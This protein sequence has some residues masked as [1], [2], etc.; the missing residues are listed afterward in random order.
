MTRRKL[1]IAITAIAAALVMGQCYMALESRARADGGPG[2]EARLDDDLTR[3]LRQ[4]KFTGRI[5]DQLERRLGRDL[6]PDRANLGRLLFFDKILGLNNDNACAGCHSPTN[7]FGDTQSIAIGVENNNVVGPGRRGPRNQRR[8]PMVLNTAFFPNLMWNSRFAAVSDDPFDNSDGFI[9][10]PPESRSL[11]YLPHLLTAQAFIPPTERNEAAGFD[12]PGTSS[13]IRAEVVRRLNQTP[14][15]RGLFRQVF[16]DIGPNEPII[17]DHLAAAIAEFEFTLTFARAPID[18]FARG[19]RGSM[20]AAEKRGALLFFGDAAC[21]S[22]HAVAGDANEMFSDFTPH[23]I[24]VP[25]I[26]P[27]V[28]NSTF[29]GP[30]QNEDFGLE[31]ITGRKADRYA[32]RTSPLRNVALNAAFFHN[33]AF[34]SLEDAIRHHLD[35]RDSALNYTP[36]GRLAPDLTGP[37]GP[38]QPVL[39]RVDQ[40]LRPPTRLTAG[41]FADLVAFVRTG[42]LDPRALPGRLTALIPPRLPSGMEPLEFQTGN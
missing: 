1:L 12:F 18:L 33:G 8:T 6:D 37:T 32:F 24:G 36:V 28:S 19:E 40:R 27:R 35:V 5:E 9:F 16:R 31:Q 29:D 13:D 10:P 11:S 2:N 25:Q 41:E 39:A 38:I 26:M 14:N 23:V 42:L 4:A 3:V 22:C 34:T 17:Y 7:G 15:Y 21:V 30:N 20:T